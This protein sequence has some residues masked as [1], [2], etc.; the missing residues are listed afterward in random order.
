MGG[1]FS[2]L[3]TIVEKSSLQPNL[4]LTFHSTAKWKAHFEASKETN[5]LVITFDII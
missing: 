4:I 5:K 1:N 2:N 3:E